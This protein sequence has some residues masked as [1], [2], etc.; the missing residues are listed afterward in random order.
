MALSKVMLFT[1]TYDRVDGRPGMRPECRESVEGQ[2]IDVEHEWVIGA[3]NPYKIGDHRNVLHQYQQAREVFLA[4]TAEALITIEHDH[5]LPDERLVQR[6]IDTTA[7]I[8]YAP[9]WLRHGLNQ[10][11]LYQRH[12]WHQLGLSLSKYPDEL[13]EARAA[14]IWPVSGSGFGCT[15]IRRHVLEA[16]PFEA[17]T[18]QNPSPDI[19]FALKALHLRFESVGRMDAALE[20][21]SNGRWW[22]AWGEPL[23]EMDTS[24]FID[25]QWIV[26]DWNGYDSLQ[27]AFCDFDTLNGVA[28]ARERAAHCPRCKD[29]KRTPVT[30]RNKGGSA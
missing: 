24:D 22:S 26:E 28:A 11:N 4:G 3:E 14:E 13:A 5:R 23:G 12:G 9:Y 29:R 18:A 25:D 8:V 19:G 6:L 21:W 2:Q 1:P 20:H 7:D 27:C 16:I 17:S 15:L 30:W 10:V